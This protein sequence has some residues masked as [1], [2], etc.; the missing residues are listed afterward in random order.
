VHQRAPR[1]GPQAPVA[2]LTPGG[3]GPSPAVSHAPRAPRHDRPSD[4][5]RRFPAAAGHAHVRPLAPLP[6]C[7]TCGPSPRAPSRRTAGAQAEELSDR[8]RPPSRRN[9][10]MT[11]GS[12]AS[13]PERHARRAVTRSSL[14]RQMRAAVQRHEAALDAGLWL[15]RLRS[16][17]PW[18]ASRRP[19]R[20]RCARPP[21][22]AR[23][24]ARGLQRRSARPWT[25]PATAPAGRLPAVC[26]AAARRARAAR[27][28]LPAAHLARRWATC[29]ATSRAARSTRWV[30][31]SATVRW[32]AAALAGWRVLRCNPSVPGRLR[33][34]A[35]ARP[36]LFRH[37][38]L[39]A[40]DPPGTAPNAT[41]TPPRTHPLRRPRKP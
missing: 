17:S 37:L 15:L 20:S 16:A 36:A 8:S 38:G 32:P 27:A 12:A 28:R 5:G 40:D 24:A 7:T 4:A 33:P 3:D 29:A 34:R 11:S 13:V 26:C 30:R 18:R 10:W 39:G 41:Q 31:C 19:I 1:Q 21:W 2:G 6:A 14:K 23:G 22:R 25:L 9:L 35:P